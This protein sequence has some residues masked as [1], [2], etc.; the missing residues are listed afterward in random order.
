[1]IPWV[2]SMTSQALKRQWKPRHK[3]LKSSKVFNKE[4]HDEESQA[5]VNVFSKKNS[6]IMGI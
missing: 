3:R 5:K 6:S 2:N 4:V 1:M